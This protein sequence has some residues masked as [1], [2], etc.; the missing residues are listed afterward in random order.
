MEPRG[1]ELPPP[2]TRTFPGASA[3]FRDL[4]RAKDECPGFH[5]LARSTSSLKL[6][7]TNDPLRTAPPKRARYALAIM[8]NRYYN[9][10]E[11]CYNHAAAAP[12]DD[13]NNNMMKKKR[14]EESLFSRVAN[15]S[16]STEPILL[17]ILSRIDTLED[18]ARIHRIRC[19]SR[20][21]EKRDHWLLFVSFSFSFLYSRF[22]LADIATTHPSQL[23]SF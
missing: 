19:R 9:N 8:K 22:I 17:K 11:N 1:T 5:T 6:I 23:V 18:D 10:D 7:N 4:I 20:T 3:T 13:G 15:L 16:V 2:I 14:K 12:D 21:E